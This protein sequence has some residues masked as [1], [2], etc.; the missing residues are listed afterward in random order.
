MLLRDE[1]PKVGAAGEDRCLRVLHKEFG[2]LRNR[3]G[4][5]ELSS[6]RFDERRAAGQRGEVHRACRI[7]GSLVDRELAHALARREDRPVAGA[8]AQVSGHRV[9]QASVVGRQAIF[10][11][12]IERH[13]DS[14]RA[15]AALRAVALD[16]GLLHRMQLITAFQRFDG[17]QLAA[18]ERTDEENAARRGEVGHRAGRAELG[19]DDGAG[20][21]VAFGAAFLRAG[22]PAALAQPGE[23]GARRV[24]AG[25]RDALAVERCGLSTKPT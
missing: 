4:N 8:A 2:E 20:A 23:H 3:A 14:R 22:E 6:G 7:F 17:D 12:R 21:A 1:E 11:M 15:E 25:K 13:H 19:E 5:K 10:I 24:F 9:A 18:I 16:H